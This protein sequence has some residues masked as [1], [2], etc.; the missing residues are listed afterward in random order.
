MKQVWNIYQKD[1]FHNIGVKKWFK[2]SKL[3]KAFEE[4]LSTLEQLTD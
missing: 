3:T 4:G 1:R 2:Y